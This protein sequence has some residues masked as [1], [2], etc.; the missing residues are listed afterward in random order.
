MSRSVVMAS[1]EDAPHLTPQ[2][3]DELWSSIPPYQRDARSKGIPQLGAG[4]IY[5]VSESE[6]VVDDFQIPEYWP[7]A[8]GMDVGW[9]KTAAVWGAWDRQTDIFYLWSE[10]Y[11]G[12]AEPVIHAEGIK[13]R[14]DWV[15]GVI[16]TAARGRGQKDGDRLWDIYADLGLTLFKADKSVEAGLYKVWTRLSTGRLKVFKSLQNWLSEYRIYRRD[17]DG[18]VV[19]ENDHLMDCT[20]YLIMS[21]LDIA[22]TKPFDE[23]DDDFSNS[24]Q[25][26]SEIGGY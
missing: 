20:R 7:V 19:K 13:A 12:A 8:Y 23:D 4:A 18:K 15:P 25:G 16:D 21:G 26:R 1:W 2:E 22:I 14:G 10:Y 9:N 17:E 6:I 5:P 11:K 24:R 3:R